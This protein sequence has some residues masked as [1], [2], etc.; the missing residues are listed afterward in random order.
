MQRGKFIHGDVRITHEDRIK[1][2]ITT[3]A[4]N[5]D[6]G[7]TVPEEFI[8]EALK[9]ASEDKASGGIKKLQDGKFFERLH[10]DILK[11]KEGRQ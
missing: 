10:A 9:Y 4:A 6:P 11:F 1:M 8:N 3:A 5:M 7:Y 2:A